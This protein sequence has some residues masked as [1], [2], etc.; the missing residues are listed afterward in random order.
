[1][2]VHGIHPWTRPR[3]RSDVRWRL[4]ASWTQIQDSIAVDCNRLADLL[5]GSIRTPAALALD[6][7]RAIARDIDRRHARMA[8]TLI[9]GG[10]FD[11]RP[12]REAAAQRELLDQALTRCRARIAELHRLRHVTIAAVRPVFSLIAW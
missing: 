11:R 3:F 8:A 12:E 10:L 1:M 2:G 7:E 4:D 6:R 5:S 9:Q